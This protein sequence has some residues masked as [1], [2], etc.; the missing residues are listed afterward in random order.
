MK[1]G[2]QILAYNCDKRFEELITPW[3]NL[4]NKYNLKIWVGS[5]Q[6]KIYNDLGCENLNDNTIKLLKKMLEENKIDYLFQPDPNNLLGDHSTRDKCIPWMREND[7]DLMIQLDSDEFYTEEEVGN[8]IGFIEDNPNYNYLTVFNNLIEDGNKGY[9]WKKHTA[10]WIKRFGGISHYYYDAHWSYAGEN[11]DEMKKGEE[12]GNIEYRRPNSLIIP[13]KLVHPKHYTWTDDKNVGG[14][15]HVS[16][17]IEYQK[18]YY[19]DEKCGY[20]WNDQLTN[21]E[22]MKILFLAGH[23]STGGMPQ[24]LLKRIK[25]LQ[26]YNPNIEIF[27]WE[28]RCLAIDY[29]VQREQIIDLIDDDKFYS[30]GHGDYKTEEEIKESQENILNYL[31]KNKIDIVHVEGIAEYWMDENIQKDLYN[32]NNS[33]KVVETSHGINWNREEDKKYEPNSYAFVTNSHL[34]RYPDGNN[35]LIEYPIDTSIIC[36]KLREEILDKGWRQ[37]GEYHIVNVGLWTPG[38]N[39]GYTIE[40]AKKLY[41][42][43]GVTYIFHFIGNQAPNFQHYWEP[44]MKDLPPN[45]MVYGEKNGDEIAEFYKMADLMLFSSTWE[46]NPVVLKEAISNNIKIIAF[47]LDHYGNDYIDFI[48]PLNGNINHDYELLLNTIHSPKKYNWKN[49]K[50]LVNVKEFASKHIEFYKTIINNN[51]DN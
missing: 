15:S 50:N 30:C 5:G 42:K 4:K 29:N 13:K 18:I 24:F 17:K 39:Q 14:P 23:L 44:L 11:N 48:E 28:W 40:L 41:E 35:V 33:W 10:W 43:Y 47:D 6:F 19:D 27:V 37:N 49:V 45:I 46:C 1:I 16:E 8:Y 38:K 12:N 7:I 20:E 21:T 34:E 25:S 22:N 9:D 3:I 2:I 31:N 36:P 26:K 32:P 51:L